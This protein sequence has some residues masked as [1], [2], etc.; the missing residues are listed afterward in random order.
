M[1]DPAARIIYD[2]PIS[3]VKGVNPEINRISKE[4]ISQ[5]K[6]EFTY[7]RFGKDPRILDSPKWINV[8]EAMQIYTNL[9]E[10][11]GTFKITNKVD[12]E[13]AIKSPRMRIVGAPEKSDFSM[14][15][16]CAY[17]LYHCVSDT[18]AAQFSA[19]IFM[20]LCRLNNIYTIFEI[21]DISDIFPRIAKYEISC[22]EFE[23]IMLD[24][25]MIGD[26]I[27]G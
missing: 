5:N 23:K 4:I 25:V 26:D 3:T 1:L 14:I 27:D 11:G 8:D 20:L 12:F 13:N 15:C 10:I 22:D 24:Y 19:T 6:R 2:E 7:M 17:K 18:V 16:E 21:G 9:L